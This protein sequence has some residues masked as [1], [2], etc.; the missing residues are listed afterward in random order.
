[1]NTTESHS[2]A[3]YRHVFTVPKSAVDQNGHVNNVTYVQWMQDVA[4]L[5]SDAT[6][7]TRAMHRAGAT[8][9]VR[10]HK[11]EYLKPAFAG[12]EVTALTWVVNFRRVRSLRRYRFLRQRDNTLLARGETEWVLVDARS[13]R[14]QKI[15]DEIIR[16]LPLV[17]NGVE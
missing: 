8:W 11:I 7:G 2:S 4:I 13:G 6:G 1:M 15:P 14:P 9:V 12:E 3:I 17:E 5:H 10:S 16:L